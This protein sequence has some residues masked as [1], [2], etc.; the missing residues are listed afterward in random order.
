MYL[1]ETV[2]PAQRY[3]LKDFNFHIKNI[4]MEGGKSTF[5]LS[6]PLEYNKLIYQLSMNGSYR[7]FMSSQTIKGLDLKG[8]VNDLGFS[9]SGDAATMSDN[10][11]PNMDGE[12]GLEMLKF[13]GLVPRNP[14]LPCL[15]A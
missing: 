5:A 13:S 15:P 1:D 11:T 10:F 3:D 7:Y 14:S 8:S 6:T 9:L 4:S 2:T 12:A